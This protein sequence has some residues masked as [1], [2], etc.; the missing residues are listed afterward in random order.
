LRARLPVA[1]RHFAVT[2]DIELG[3]W[4]RLARSI[5]RRPFAY[6]GAGAAV[7]VAAA[8]PVFALQL[9]PGSAEG[10]PRSPQSVHG[11]DVLRAAVGPGAISPAQVLVDG[12]SPGGVR[13][14]ATQAA[15]GRLVDRLRADPEVENAFY[16]AGGRFVDPSGRYAQVIVAGR[17]EY[18]DEASQSL[19][20]RMRH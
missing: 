1:V 6:L 9:T 3:W 12:G 5:M 20:S 4:A 13:R 7:L 17:H 18:G 11:F 19:V 15:I 2:G 16:V 8:I 10:I 14:L